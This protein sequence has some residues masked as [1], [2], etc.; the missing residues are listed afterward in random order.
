MIHGKVA[1]ALKWITKNQSKVLSVDESVVEKLKLKHPDASEPLLETLITGVAPS[2][3]A[4][5]FEH[6]T[7]DTIQKAAKMMKGAAGPSGIDS[8]LWKRILCSK[9]YGKIA[10]NACDSIARMSRRLCTGYVDPDSISSLVACRLIPLDKNPAVYVP[11]ALA[12]VYGASWAKPLLT[13]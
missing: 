10:T 3:E 2:V 12:S 4:V 1:A 5:I 6:I 8:D 7:G 11:S 9:S 13:F